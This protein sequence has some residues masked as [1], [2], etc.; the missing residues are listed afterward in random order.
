MS[1]DRPARER[2]D[3]LLTE[4]EE[5]VLETEDI[6]PT[7][8]AAMRS[9]AESAIEN[10]MGTRQGPNASPDGVTL[11]Q[12]NVTA[13][14]ERLGRWTGM[15]ESADWQIAPPVRM[16]FSGENA[17]SQRKRGRSE[18]PGRDVQGRNDDEG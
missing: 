17:K 2:L 1:N 9:L 14:M 10:H 11:A 16:A 7:E 13:A 18:R 3:A 6:L 5:D 4:L 15:G 12:G 8:V